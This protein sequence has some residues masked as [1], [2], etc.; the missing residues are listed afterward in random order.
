MGLLLLLM[1]FR[2]DEGRHRM[3][4]PVLPIKPRYQL[5]VGLV[6]ETLTGFQLFHQPAV[7][8]GIEARRPTARSR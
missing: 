5:I 6:R 7:A 3:A 2:V 8:I 1:V 4:L